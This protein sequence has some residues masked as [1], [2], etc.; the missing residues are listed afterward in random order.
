MATITWKGKKATVKTT[1]GDFV[2]T[3]KK[4]KGLS[5]IALVNSEGVTLKGGFQ[6]MVLVKTWLEDYCKYVK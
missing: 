1:S 5:S 4:V 6:N 3:A 2:Y